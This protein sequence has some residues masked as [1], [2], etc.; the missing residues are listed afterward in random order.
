MKFVNRFGKQS[1]NH[2][3]TKIYSNMHIKQLTFKYK[4]KHANNCVFSNIF[5]VVSPNNTVEWF[6]N[7]ANQ[8]SLVVEIPLFTTGFTMF[9]TSQV[10]VGDF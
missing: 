5:L 10:V 3:Y 6:R 7:P 1:T 9:Y 2:T 8:L 4:C